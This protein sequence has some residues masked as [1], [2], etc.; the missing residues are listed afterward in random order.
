MQTRDELIDVLLAT[1]RMP[2]IGGD[3]VRIGDRRFVDGAL[4]SPIPIEAALDAGATHV[5]VLQTRPYGVPRTTGS[6]VGERLVERQLRRLNPA[7]GA[8]WR[9]RAVSYEALVADIARRSQHPGSGPPHVLGLRPPAGTP[10][11]S[12]LERRPDV[13]RRA[14]QDGERL[15]EA[16]LLEAVAPEAALRAAG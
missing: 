14:A 5:L 2:W 11:V 6:A 1:T 12:Q 10:V 16:A 13:L 4:V 3:P 8:L 9:E 15:V 7:L